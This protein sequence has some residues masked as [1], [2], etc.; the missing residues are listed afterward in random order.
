M[1]MR[2]RYRTNLD[3]AQRAVWALNDDPPDQALPVG[4][5]VVLPIG[6]KYFRLRVTSHTYLAATKT[7]EVELHLEPGV[8][9]R[10]FSDRM[11]RLRTGYGV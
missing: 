11:R 1:A 10:D 3:E 9:I 8:T 2:V 6:D 4:T 5:S 7:L